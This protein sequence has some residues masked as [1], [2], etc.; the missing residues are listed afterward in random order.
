MIDENSFLKQIMQAIDDDRLPLPTLPEV[1][2]QVQAAVEDDASTVKEIADI[3]M[4]D[5]AL[6]ARLLQVANSPLYRGRVAVENIQMAVSRLGGKLV[7]GLVLS[8]IMRQM[9]QATSEVLDRHLRRMW[10]DSTTVAAI[11]RVLSHN[12]PHL[13]REQAMLA[14]LIHNIGALPLL[15]MAEDTPGLRDDEQEIDRLIERI[16]PEIGKRIM[17]EWG[18]PETLAKVPTHCYDVSYDGGP[19]ADYVDLVIAARLQTRP[20]CVAEHLDLSQVPAIR[21]VG[22][23]PELEILEIKGVAE[24]VEE[25]E[26]ILL[27]T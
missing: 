17:K 13:E 10:E 26:H 3:I 21:K 18:F 7:K 12:T 6:S 2:L 1:A 25:V 16:G 22:L 8:L 20:H 27:S 14:G 4:I 23:E 11:S 24:E 5:A 19:E 9:Y 15:V